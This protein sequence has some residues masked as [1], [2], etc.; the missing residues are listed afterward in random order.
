MKD[1]KTV[2]F[3]EDDKDEAE[4]YKRF[5]ERVGNIRIKTIKPSVYPSLS[6]YRK[7]A[8]DASTGAFL[9]DQRLDQSGVGYTGMEVAD[10]LRQVKPEL[11]IYMLTG[12]PEDIQGGEAAG[13]VED[14]IR[15]SE[16]RKW[17]PQYVARILRSI[18]R[19][20]EAMIERQKRLDGL[21]DRKLAGKLTKAEES[22]LQQL[23]H[24]IERPYGLELISAVSR[25]EKAEEDELG[26]L[27]RISE[28]LNKLEEKSKATRG[29]V[30]RARSST[31]ARG[32]NK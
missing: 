26:L 17:A 8:T 13:Q 9:I 15:K 19:Y 11:P 14:V 10:Y 27:Q 6:D 22:E 18:Q 20:E 12:Y 32:A 21:I 23:R 5:L 7:L 3:V 28:R 2:W 31:K 1:H 25:R 16:V 4:K 30:S 24:A 29:K